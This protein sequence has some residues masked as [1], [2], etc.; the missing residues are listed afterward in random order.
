MQPLNTIYEIPTPTRITPWN[1]PKPKKKKKKRT[2][3]GPV[4]VIIT[5]PGGDE[6]EYKSVNLAAGAI[7][8]HYS[9]VMMLLAGK[10]SKKFTGFEA[11]YA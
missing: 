10:E 9:T 2:T 4:A 8:C 6:E 3:S 11:R 1:L 7:G 5:F